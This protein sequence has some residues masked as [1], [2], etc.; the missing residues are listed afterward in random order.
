[1]LV[2]ATQNPHKYKEIASI[3]SPIE[4]ISAESNINFPP[5]TGLTFI[6]NAILKARFLAKI[7]HS[8]C[9]ADDSGLIVPSLNNEPG[10]YS[11]RYAGAHASDKDNRHKLLSILKKNKHLDRKAFFYCAI[12]YLSHADDTMPIITTGLWEGEIIL[13]ETGTSGFGYDPIFYL[14]NLNKTVAELNNEQKNHLSHRA[15]ALQ[16]LK[17]ILTTNE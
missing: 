11:A 5:E 1:M 7:C 9:L 10:L 17:R 6:E 16:K 2:I 14:S 15:Q 4:C 12:A 3:L 13:T 8:P